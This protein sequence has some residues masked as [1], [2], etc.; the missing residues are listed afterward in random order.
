LEST[1]APESEKRE[2][3]G[4]A[5]VSMVVVVV[6]MVV[7][8]MSL[9][10]HDIA[11]RRELVVSRDVEAVRSVFGVANDGNNDVNHG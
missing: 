3:H 8:L 4:A 6:M 2:K 5:G 1:Q 7:V 10:Q 11:D 9:R